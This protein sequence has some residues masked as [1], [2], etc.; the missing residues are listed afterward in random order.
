MSK[1]I[2]RLV[3]QQNNQMNIMVIHDHKKVCE[4]KNNN[5]ILVYIYKFKIRCKLYKIEEKKRFQKL[6]QNVFNYYTEH[7]FIT[8]VFF[9][10][11]SFIHYGPIRSAVNYN[12][13]KREYSELKRQ[14]ER[15]EQEITRMGNSAVSKKKRLLL[16]L[17]LLFEKMVG[18]YALFLFIY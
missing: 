13:F 5:P 15:M 11:I 4:I 7:N 18:L 12:E 14:T 3:E 9:L 2:Q 8:E 16:L 10:T 6:T 17:L 1:K